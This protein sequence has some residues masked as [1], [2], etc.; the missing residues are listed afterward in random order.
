[1]PPIH[2][3][4]PVHG[5]QSTGYQTQER[6]PQ[7]PSSRTPAGS[8]GFV[9]RIAGLLSRY[10]N[11]RAMSHANFVFGMLDQLQ[12]IQGHHA[13]AENRRPPS[14]ADP[15]HPSRHASH[16]SDAP[17]GAD[18]RSSRHPASD[19]AHEVREMAAG[20]QDQLRPLNDQIADVLDRMADLMNAGST[21][22]PVPSAGVRRPARPTGAQGP[23]GPD[24]GRGNIDDWLGNASG[25]DSDPDTRSERD[26]EDRFSTRSGASLD[27]AGPGRHRAQPDLPA[28]PPAGHADETERDRQ[29][30]EA[31]AILTANGRVDTQLSEEGRRTAVQITR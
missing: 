17:S 21:P 22:R 6:E 12:G 3:N 1:M 15:A 18:E 29:L 27:S 25:A 7:R 13:Q 14:A 4:R 19:M 2:N 23:A 30:R 16:A 26:D 5:A 20:I 31:S 8:F 24:R 11:G 28:Q 9:G 10:A